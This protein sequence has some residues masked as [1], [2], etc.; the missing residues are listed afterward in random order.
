M[1]GFA[2]AVLAI[3]VC[4]LGSRKLWGDQPGNA[5]VLASTLTGIVA[6][7]ASWAGINRLTPI[8]DHS[9]VMTVLAL[10]MIVLGAFM[11]RSGPRGHGGP[12][13]ATS[14]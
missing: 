12:T 5:R 3:A 14:D 10:E 9:L 1:S 13:Q 7:T 4:V 8:P 6:A 2:L 11:V